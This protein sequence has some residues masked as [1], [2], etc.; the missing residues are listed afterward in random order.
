MGSEMCIRDSLR[1]LS[2]EFFL[3][4]GP[5][6]MDQIMPILHGQI[7]PNFSQIH[8]WLQYAHPLP[9]LP[10]I[11][12]AGQRMHILKPWKDLAEIRDNLSMEYRLGRLL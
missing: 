3:I 12:Q 6:I 1:A 9:S 5:S 2:M 7:I 8:P 10:S 4:V 11:G